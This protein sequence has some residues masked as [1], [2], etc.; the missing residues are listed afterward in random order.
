M[1]DM[2]NSGLANFSNMSKEP[3]ELNKVKQK[4]FVEVNEEGSEA[5]AITGKLN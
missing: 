2:F 3:L 4:A 5:A 1:S